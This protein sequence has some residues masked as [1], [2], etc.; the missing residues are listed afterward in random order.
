MTK[1]N[2]WRQG[3][4]YPPWAGLLGAEVLQR[5]GVVI[6]FEASKLARPSAQAR[7][8]T[9]SLAPCNR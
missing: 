3:E 6:D 8:M 1:L 5:L 2:E 7:T 9:P 4:G